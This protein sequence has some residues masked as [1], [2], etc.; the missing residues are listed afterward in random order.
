MPSSLIIAMIFYKIGKGS[1]NRP[2]NWDIS[3]GPSWKARYARYD[4]A[5]GAT[6]E[7][8][9]KWEGPGMWIVEGLV[10][11]LGVSQLCSMSNGGHG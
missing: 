11:Q 3:S 8:S 4:R 6:E 2:R 1:Q 10:G 5:R 9:S 7:Q